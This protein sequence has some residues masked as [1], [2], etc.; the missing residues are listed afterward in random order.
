MWKTSE[1]ANLV[2]QWIFVLIS[3]KHKFFPACIVKYYFFPPRHKLLKEGVLQKNGVRK[4][5]QNWKSFQ[6][7][8][9]GL[10]IP[11]SFTKPFKTNVLQNSC[12]QL[13]SI[14]NQSK[15]SPY[16]KYTCT[17]CGNTNAIHRKQPFWSNYLL[18][19]YM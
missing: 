13:V 6:S 3:V 16:S 11:L 8:V 7:K 19:M 18:Y 17:Y 15:Y 2:F 10:G 4:L 5:F 12:E 1:A 9:L 14:E